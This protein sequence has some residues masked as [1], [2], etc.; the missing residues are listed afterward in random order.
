[1]SL[2]ASQYKGTREENDFTTTIHFDVRSLSNLGVKLSYM[3]Y[4]NLHQTVLSANHK[5]LLVDCTHG[6][7]RPFQ[8]GKTPW[9]SQSLFL[10]ISRMLAFLVDQVCLTSK[11]KLFDMET[12][13][14]PN[15]QGV[16]QSGCLK[17][18]GYIDQISLNWKNR[19]AMS[20]SE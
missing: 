16:Q 1:M 11:G 17:F 3:N 4:S 5:G 12:H 18:Y 19:T 20:A 6:F 10:L 9:R 7:Q 15:T 13:D 14:L 2:Y 8:L